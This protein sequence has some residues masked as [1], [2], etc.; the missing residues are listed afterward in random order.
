M[1]VLLA[2]LTAPLGLF[3]AVMGLF[4][5]TVDC[6]A[7]MG[8]VS[9]VTAM[10]VVLPG[11]LLLCVPPTVLADRRRSPAWSAVAGLAVSFALLAELL[12]AIDG[13]ANLCLP[14]A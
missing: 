14:P 12:I 3:C 4:A 13:P 11:L 9:R 1:T 10:A 6:P 2:V 5:D 8:L 7:D